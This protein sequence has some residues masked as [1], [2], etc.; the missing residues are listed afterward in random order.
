MRKITE[1]GVCNDA[2]RPIY[3]PSSS[4]TYAPARFASHIKEYFGEF[5]GDVEVN[6]IFFG[7]SEASFKGHASDRAVI[8]GLLGLSPYDSGFERVKQLHI[9]REGVYV[10]VNEHENVSFRFFINEKKLQNIAFGIYIQL[11]S[12]RK[13]LEI[14]GASLGGGDVRVD[15]AIRE[16]E[17]MFPPFR[18]LFSIREAAWPISKENIERLRRSKFNVNTLDEL[19]KLSE[20][21]GKRISRIVIER[22]K[23]LVGK[24][25]QDIL[26]FMRE[27][28]RLM[29][30]NIQEGLKGEYYGELTLDIA[31]LL[32]TFYKDSFFAER[33][34][35]AYALA[36][37]LV[38]ASIGRIVTSPTAGSAGILPA[39]AYTLYKEGF[40]ESDIVESLFTAGI[41][42]LL[43]KSKASVSGAQHGCQAECGVARAM[44]AALETELR[45]GKPFQIINAVGHAIK[46]SLGLPCDPIG[47][48]VEIPCILRNGACAVAAHNDAAIALAGFKVCPTPDEILNVM[49]K[50]GK[51][52]KIKYKE[53]GLGGIARTGTAMEMMKNLKRT[54][55]RYGIPYMRTRMSYSDL[56]SRLGTIVP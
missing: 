55:H 8:G 42:C 2:L 40:P 47:G 31:Q 14:V 16:P 12:E 33:Q 45:G 32:S 30:R 36:V 19:A 50:V 51:D 4:H 39:V 26:N 52:M 43:I 17:T 1:M 44:A 22:E 37:A 54:S 24:D 56:L 11:W 7:G 35:Y 25:E 46:E 3:G 28:W 48:L 13:T 23:L 18:D 34:T 27:N 9:R 6:I 41:I 5:G 53:T 10:V 38:N 20:S 49:D 29:K 15:A 21:E